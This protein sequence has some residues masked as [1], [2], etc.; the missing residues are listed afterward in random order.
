[1][2]DLKAAIEAGSDSIEIIFCEIFFHTLIIPA[3]RL[4]LE[5]VVGVISKV[6]PNVVDIFSGVEEKFPIK[7][8]KKIDCVQSAKVAFQ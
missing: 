5:N 4:N 6:D 7:D 3:D 1:M 2:E 8:H